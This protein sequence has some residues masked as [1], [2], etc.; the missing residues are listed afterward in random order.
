MAEKTNP[1]HPVVDCIQPLIELLHEKNFLP[2][3][4][5]CPDLVEEYRRLDVEMCYMWLQNCMNT[6][7]A[8]DF[9]TKLDSCLH[10]W[11]RLINSARQIKGL[12]WDL[13]KW[14]DWFDQSKANLC[15]KEEWDEV[16]G[17][18]SCTVE[19]LQKLAVLIKAKI[20]AKKEADESQPQ[21]PVPSAYEGNGGQIEPK[22]PEILQK[23][24]WV[25]KY[26]RRYWWIILLAIIL[27]L[28]LKILPRFF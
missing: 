2:P 11:A 24:L 20:T 26:G 27:M 10:N 22:P 6:A 5:K 13:L 14:Q 21:K 17:E 28:F 12:A 8:R 4:Y 9:N 25:W 15:F 7:T 3:F 19:F 1:W 23:I 18:L 16:M